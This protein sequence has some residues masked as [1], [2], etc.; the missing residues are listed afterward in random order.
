LLSR[1][2]FWGWPS[3]GRTPRPAD[4]KFWARCAEAGVVVHLI[5][6]GRAIPSGPRGSGHR[7]RSGVHGRDGKPGG[8]RPIEVL[9]ADLVTTKNANLSWIVLT[10]VSKGS[11]HQDRGRASASGLARR[12]R[13]ALGLE[14][15]VCPVGTWQWLCSPEGL[16]EQ[17]PSTA[18]ALYR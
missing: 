7:R 12:L 18:G 10:G 2:H 8:D 13:G 17:L 4:D 9:V 11:S 1:H 14:L 16:A 15:P 6:G 3:G 5:R